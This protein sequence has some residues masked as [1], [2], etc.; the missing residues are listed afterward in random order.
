MR[1]END[2]MQQ[3]EDLHLERIRTAENIS[4]FRPMNSDL[5]S[6]PRSTIT[7]L[8]ELLSEFTGSEGTFWNWQRQLELVRITYNLDDNSTCILISMK[9]KQRVLQ[10]FHSK[11]EHLEIPMTELINQMKR[12]FDRLMKMK[13]HRRRKAGVAMNLSAII[14]TI[15]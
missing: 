2:L 8:G 14:I 15:K 4:I 5:F 13:L 9:L 11:P 6:M 3:L 12:I 10:W 1:C 7:V